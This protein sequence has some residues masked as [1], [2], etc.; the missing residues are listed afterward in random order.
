MKKSIVLLALSITIS[1]CLFG[2]KKFEVVLSFPDTLSLADLRI[3]IDNGL[4]RTSFP[5]KVADNN[6]VLLSDFYYSRYAAVI[7]SLPKTENSVYKNFFFLDDK[8]ARIN[9]LPAA[10]D[11]SPLDHYVLTNAYDFISERNKMKTYSAAEFAEAN[12]YFEKYGSVIFDGNHKDLQEQFFKL[13]AGIYKKDIEY[14]KKTSNSYFSFWYFRSNAH[15]SG[16]AVDSILSIFDSTFPL[17]FRKST[18]GHAYRQLL[19]GKLGT[20]K[21]NFAAQFSIND[22]NGNRITLSSF[23]NKKYVL[24]DFWATW[25]VACIKEMPL[26]SSLREKYT[27][28]L[29][30][31]SIAYPTSIS[32]AK[33]LIAKQKMNWINIYNDINLINSYGGMGAIPK[34]ILID[35]FGKIVYDNQKDNDGDLKILVALLEQNLVAK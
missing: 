4:G 35:K 1:S 14:I 24:L 28:E 13:D 6:Q 5:Y 7:V 22:I 12:K 19:I 9:F 23:K 20:K 31:I 21:G 15:Y 29:E 11:S 17:S 10:K 30:I 27:K 33:D 18:E 25:C 8:P 32:Q 3:Q 16:L 26:L 2:Q 34:L